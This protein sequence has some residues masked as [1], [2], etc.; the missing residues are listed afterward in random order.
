MP[1]YLHENRQETQA[2][3]PHYDFFFA[4]LDNFRIHQGPRVLARQSQK[5][6]AP[7]R[8]NLRGGDASPIPRR[9]SP[10]RQRVSEILHQRPNR[11]CGRVFHLLCYLAQ[12]RVSQLQQR[13]NRHVLPP[14]RASAFGAFLNPVG[15]SPFYLNSFFAFLCLRVL[16]VKIS[17]GFSHFPDSADRNTASITAIF[18]IASSSGTGTSPPS[19]IARENASPCTVYWLQVGI[20]SVVI[21]LPK[22]SLP[23]STKISHGRSFGAL[24][25]ILISIRP[26]VPKN[27]MRWYRTSCVPHAN[28]DCPEGNSNIAE[29]SRSVPNSGSLSA[30][31]ATRNGSSP[32]IHRDVVIG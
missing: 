13:S 16:C 1:L 32:K 25:G 28:T 26:F 29:A 14:L 2:R 3:V 27:C 7:I 18:A 24:K 22:M 21:P 19:R 9:L 8:A 15:A 30:I 11:R 6:H 31:P 4:S 17:S 5:N 10:I 20:I 12:S 23:S